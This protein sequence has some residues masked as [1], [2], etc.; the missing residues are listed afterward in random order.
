MPHIKPIR[1]KLVSP[2]ALPFDQRSDQNEKNIKTRN[3]ELVTAS[4]ANERAHPELRRDRGGFFKKSLGAA[5]GV[6]KS[7]AKNARPSQIKRNVKAVVNVAKPLVKEAGK[8]VGASAALYFGAG[9]INAGAS[10]ATAVS[11]SSS[12]VFSSTGALSNTGTLL[13]LGTPVGTGTVIAGTTSSGTLL[14]GGALVTS[15]AVV[16]AGTVLLPG[17]AGVA[18][19]GLSVSAGKLATAKN[20]VGANSVLAKTATSAGTAGVGTVLKNTSQP[21]GGF[22][23]KLLNA[24]EDATIT[25]LLGMTGG[26]LNNDT[27]PRSLTATPQKKEGDGFPMLLVLALAV[28]VALILGAGALRMNKIT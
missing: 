12:G 14:T 16:G 15:G 2:R 25:N 26:A 13:G 5:G 23:N 4:V 9:A 3:D 19:T 6:V 8:F 11:A 20:A 21:T 7:A 27:K 28:G 24:G 1:A 22:V 18:Q 10:G 17:S